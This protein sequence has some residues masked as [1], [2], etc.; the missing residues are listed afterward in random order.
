MNLICVNGTYHLT[1]YDFFC[2]RQQPEDTYHS[3]IQCV[4]RYDKIKIILD[5]RDP[6]RTWAKNIN[7]KVWLFGV[8]DP[9][10]NEIILIMKFYLHQVRSSMR[11]LSTT[12]LKQEIYLRILSEKSI[13]AQAILTQNGQDLNI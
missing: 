6:N 1:Q 5:H 4:W 11:R 13:K 9:A 10:V 3:F 8:G 2:D 12:G 7:H